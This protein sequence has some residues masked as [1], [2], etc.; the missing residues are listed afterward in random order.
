[1][2]DQ[3]YT[4]KSASQV[5]GISRPALRTY[6]ARYG[7]YLSTHATPESGSPRQ[8]TGDDLRVLRFVYEL[9]SGG[10]THELVQERLAAGALDEFD[11]MPPK[12]ARSSG[13]EDALDGSTALVTREQ[14][15]S[16]QLLMLDAQ[17]R[18]NE[19]LEREKAAQAQIAEL[20][21]ALGQAEGELQTLKTFKRRPRWLA[22]LFGE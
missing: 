22:A 20:Q 18:E 2:S 16:M 13:A 8:F 3:L 14:V 9:T 21:R 17:R 1:M 15:Q 12:P 10:A 6:T 5:T 4:T 7:R 11:W 19:A